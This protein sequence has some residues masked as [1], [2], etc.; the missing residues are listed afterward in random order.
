MYSSL[1]GWPDK[2]GGLLVPVAVSLS[3]NATKFFEQLRLAT[4]GLY[5]LE[6]DNQKDLELTRG[7]DYRNS[8]PKGICLMLTT[9]FTTESEYLQALGRVRR[10]AD[11]GQVWTLP[12]KMWLRD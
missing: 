4:S 12:D 9:P 2:Q 8:Q 10:H 1:E 5:F 3:L 6:S 7:V 11:E